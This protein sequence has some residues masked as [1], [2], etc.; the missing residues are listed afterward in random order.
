MLNKGLYGV[1][2]PHIRSRD[3]PPNR[4]IVA[5]DHRCRLEAHLTLL[6]K[7]EGR[8]RDHISRGRI[9]V[10]VRNTT[11]R[12][13][14]VIE[15][16]LDQLSIELEKVMNVLQTFIYELE[17]RCLREG[18]LDVVLIESDGLIDSEHHLGAS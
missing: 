6:S 5:Q 17:P 11:S 7:R 3:L 13:A 14:Q 2:P 10:R 18:N 16:P 9:R 8:S 4:F 1:C 12:A 15:N